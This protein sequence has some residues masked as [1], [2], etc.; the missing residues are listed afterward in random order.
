M[1]SNPNCTY[2]ASDVR[3]V[4]L[5]AKVLQVL[6]EKST[7]LNNTVSHALDFP[8]PLLIQGGVV[9]DGRGNASTVN[10]GVRVEGT[11][12]NLNLGVHALLLLGGLT[13]E[14]ESTNTLTVEAHILSET[15]AQSNVVALLHKVTRSESILVSV[16]AGKTL[17]GHVE[18]G[19]VALLLHDVANLAPL[20][21]SRVNTGRVVSAG[22]EQ[23]DAI[24][25]SSLDVGKQTLEVETDGVLVVVAV[26]LHLETRVLEDSVVVGPAGGG[27]VDFL[28]VR[29]EALQESTTDSQGTGTRDGLGD[30]ET[31]VLEDGRI[32]TVGEFRSSLSE[33]RN[34]SDAGVLL[35]ETR[36]NNLVLSSANG[37]QNVGLALVVTCSSRTKINVHPMTHVTASDQSTRRKTPKGQTE[38]KMKEKR[39]KHTVSTNTQ[40]NLLL[41]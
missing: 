23:D 19:K 41:E 31:V 39:E 30:N 28:C 38:R 35:V 34:T 15:L 24:L 16:T 25:R 5:A 32:G 29:V 37:G 6:L 2:L 7:H 1:E 10:R 33:R 11:D 36:G 27:E 40:V 20:V 14:G 12:E 18:E 13:D 9:H 4:V 17:V 8:Q 3:P 21:L 22:V 26:L